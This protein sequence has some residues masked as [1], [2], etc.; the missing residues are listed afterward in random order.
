MVE[1]V[2]IGMVEMNGMV[3]MIGTVGMVGR[4]GMIGMVGMK[5]NVELVDL[6]MILENLLKSKTMGSKRKA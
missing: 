1:L 4:I 3:G 6:D 5:M 2:M